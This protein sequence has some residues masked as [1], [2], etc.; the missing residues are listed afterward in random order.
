M[1]VAV[2]QPYLFPYLGYFQL[3]QA[4]DAFVVYDNV[5][6]IRKGWINKNFI[7]ANGKSQLV[8]L[9]LSG[10]SRNKLINEIQVKGDSKILKTIRYNYRKAPNFASV[11]P[12][13]EA[14][15]ATPERNL[16]LFLESQL[17]QIC[18]LLELSP[19]WYVSS[20]LK[21]N[22]EYRGQAKI[23]SICRELGATHYINL[24]GGRGYY[25]REIFASSGLR[26]SFVEPRNVT[27]KQFGESF[28]PNLSIIDVLMFN[29]ISE[30]QKL[31][32]E[33]DLQ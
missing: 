2:M 31:L 10:A 21:E 3:I 30:C 25:D 13:V 18:S 19:L 28:I 17:R 20:H 5:N 23:L 15:L 12:F 6:Y 27:Y 22:K 11:Y 26:L 32:K 4:V 14:I 16:S 9:P 24:P 8:T 1:K 7:L 33:Y 29:K